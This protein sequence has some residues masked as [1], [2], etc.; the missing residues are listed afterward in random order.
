MEKEVFIFGH[1]KPDTDSICAS[2]VR[3]RLDKKWMELYG[4][5]KIRKS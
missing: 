4:S 2:L 5:K 1:K 3:E